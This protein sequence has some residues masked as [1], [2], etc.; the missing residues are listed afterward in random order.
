MSVQTPPTPPSSDLEVEADVIEDARARQRRHRRIGAAVLVAAVVAV[1][2]ILGFT[3]GA[4]GGT[5]VPPA[6]VALH[7]PLPAGIA[8]R[9][10]DPAGGLAWGIRIVHT[11]GYTCVQLGRLRGDQL[12][13][14]GRDGFAGDNGRFYPMGPSTTYQARCAPNDGNGHAFM[15]VELG[16]QPTSGAGS[17][18]KGLTMCKTGGMSSLPVCPVRDL[19]FVQYGL[20]GPDASGITYRIS[21][22][23]Y[24]ERAGPDGAYL[25]VGGP[26]TQSF[27]QQFGLGSPCGSSGIATGPIGGG[28]IQAVHYRNAPACQP[29]RVHPGVP[30]WLNQC[31]E[32]GYVPAR[33]TLTD[34]QVATPIRVRVIHANAYC[35]NNAR[36]PVYRFGPAPATQLTLYHPCTHPTSSRPGDVIHGTLVIFSWTA[37]QAVNSPTSDYNYMI[38]GR[39]GGMGGST[40]GEITLGERLT[41]A[42]MLQGNQSTCTATGTVGY[43]PNLGPGGGAFDDDNPGHE[44]SLLVGRFTVTEPPVRANG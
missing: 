14:L 32:A 2:A 16:S 15:R 13:L 34:R 7:G 18:Y 44:G 42:V 9:A 38:I 43:N 37:R 4:G 6:F 40:Y 41:R 25:V 31:P 35:L 19:R 26:S 8:A 3:G 5:H 22:T 29:N 36:S 27:C 1:G 24:T 23:N 39:C 33:G 11:T 12:G 30:A 10:A 17:G 20:L 21:G 28:M